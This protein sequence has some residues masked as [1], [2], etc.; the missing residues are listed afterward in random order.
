MTHVE[1]ASWLF[2]LGRCLLA[3][4]L[5]AHVACGNGPPP[6]SGGPPMAMGVEALTL[7]TRPVEQTTEYIATVKSRRST[8]IQPQVEGLITRIPVRSGQ[9]VTGG[10]VLV[11]IDSSRQVAAV[12]ALESLRAARAADV[13]FA[14][15]QAERMQTLYQAGAVSLQ[16]QE[17]AAT[18]VQTTEAQLRA[19]EAQLREQQVQLE[20]HRVTAPT[21][22]MVGDIPV[23]VGDR[24][25]SSTVL[26]TLDENAGLELY[27]SVP[28]AQASRL[29]RGLAVRL[30]D[31]R[32]EVAGTTQVDFVSPSVDT[33]TQAVLVKAPLQASS[34]LRTDQLVRVQV[35]WSS[36]PG[37]TIPLVSVTRINGQY[38]VFVV[39]KGEGGLTV[40]RQRPVELGPV[41]G[42]DYEL[43]SGLSPGDQLIVAGIQKIGD[44]APIT[45]MPAG[46]A[47]AADRESR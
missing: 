45:V 14:R 25:T 19:V 44:G 38:F 26:T 7:T 29:R 23:R 40:A 37:L 2:K 31:D 4:G 28:V 21:A 13:A 8:T 27:I 32:G 15:Q 6:P 9:L 1:T 35:V 30:I 47:A 39:D 17:Q 11:E 20:Y 18:A 5:A 12:A 22:G 10:T 3:C 34:R 41:V 33:N 43:V 16:E 36:A 42:N 46:A 24:V